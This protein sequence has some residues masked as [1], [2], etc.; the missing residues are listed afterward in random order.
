MRARIVSIANTA[1]K[2]AGSAV[3]VSSFNGLDIQGAND[4]VPPNRSLRN[5]LVFGVRFRR[6]TTS[7]Q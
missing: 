1:P 3:F 7:Q 5:L 4:E 2:K 6:S